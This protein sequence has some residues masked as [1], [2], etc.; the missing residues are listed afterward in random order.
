M[1]HVM[2]KIVPIQNKARS[3]SDSFSA[4]PNIGRSL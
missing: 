1:I 2:T 3:G 4:K